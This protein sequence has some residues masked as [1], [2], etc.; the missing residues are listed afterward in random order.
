VNFYDPSGLNQASPDGYCAPEFA[1]CDDEPGIGIGIG[2]GGGGGGGGGELDPDYANGL[3]SK[4]ELKQRRQA[5]YLEMFMAL[6]AML[7]VNQNPR[8]WPRIPTAIRKSGDCWEPSSSISATYTRVVTYEVLDEFGAPMFGS[9]LDGLT[10]TEGFPVQDGNLG[11]KPGPWS[12][13][14][15]TITASG[16]FVD[17]LSAGGGIAG[18]TRA[19]TALQTFTATGSFGRMPLEILGFGPSSGVLYNNYSPSM[20]TINGTAAAD[21]CT[22][23]Y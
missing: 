10:I 9:A 6:S 18:T 17:L 19:G 12:S 1:S 8:D 4:E 3:I 7:P 22:K 13:S 2:G 21:K 15:N 14:N 23:F 5:R 16:T 20:V 11:L